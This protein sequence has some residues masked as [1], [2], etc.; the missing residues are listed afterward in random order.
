M[1]TLSSLHLRTNSLLQQPMH[2][3]TG[4]NL[5]HFVRQCCT[6]MVEPTV[7]FV[8][9]SIWVVVQLQDKLIADRQNGHIA[10]ITCEAHNQQGHVAWEALVD[11]KRQPCCAHL[12]PFLQG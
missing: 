8:T 5:A 10:C 1:L 4:K 12:Q 11:S 2:T 6:G 7:L 9:G 3:V